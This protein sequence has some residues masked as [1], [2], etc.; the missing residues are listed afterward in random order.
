MTRRAYREDTHQVM[1]S[2]WKYRYPQYQRTS[3]LSS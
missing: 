3:R 1:D 2:N